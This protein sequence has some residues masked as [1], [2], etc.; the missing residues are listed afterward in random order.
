MRSK[1][2]FTCLQTLFSAS[3]TLAPVP[4]VTYAD[5]QHPKP[6]ILFEMGGEKCFTLRI[7]STYKGCHEIESLKA[8]IQTSID[9]MA[10]DDADV[11]NLCLKGMES[12]EPAILRY[13]FNFFERGDF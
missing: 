12:T 4:L 5:E 10:G 13:K 2:I 7:Y 1:D 3:A 11:N 9:S 6:Y 8:A